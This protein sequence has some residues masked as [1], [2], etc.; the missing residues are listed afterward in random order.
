VAAARAIVLVA[1]VSDDAHVTEAVAA[2]GEERVL[3]DLHANR[4]EKVLIR[5]RRGGRERL[6][7]CG[8]GS[9]CV[10]GGGGS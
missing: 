8:G 3:D 1:E 4:T 10:G 6:T 7:G 2:R 5:L 9:S